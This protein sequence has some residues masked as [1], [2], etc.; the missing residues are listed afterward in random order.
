VFVDV[1]VSPFRVLGRIDG[2]CGRQIDL[3]PLPGAVVLSR[4]KASGGETLE[5]VTW[6]IGPVDKTR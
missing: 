2:G 6:S 5:S 1:G 4:R 3:D